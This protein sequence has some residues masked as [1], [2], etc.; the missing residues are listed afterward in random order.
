MSPAPETTFIQFSSDDL[1]TPNRHKAIV[2]LYDHGL[3]PTNLVPLAESDPHVDFIRWAMP[4]LGILS[5]AI[6]GVRH[7]GLPDT[8]NQK[9]DDD[10]FLHICLTGTNLVCQRGREVTLGDG[11]AVLMTR[12]GTG[13][14][15]TCPTQVN[16]IGLRLP[17]LAFV[18]LVPNLDDSTG[19]LIPRDAGA[20]KLLRKYLSVIADTETLATPQLRSLAVTQIYDLVALTIGATGDA[21][22]VAEN[23]GVRAA[24]LQA[25]KTDIIA[26]LDDGDLNVTAVAARN[27]LTVRYLH[28]LFE[29]EGIRYSEFVLDQ[30]LTRAH[31]ILTSPIHAHRAIGMI[32][33]EAGFNDLSYFNRAFR[34]RYNA[35]PSEVR[36]T[37]AQS[38]RSLVRRL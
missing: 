4:G 1:P 20:L 29:T 22:E 3:L 18:Q 11:D 16:F 38:Q 13:W 30:R 21:H 33:F 28:K 26:N 2:E 31:R 12:E 6:S 19:C 23:R 7:Q 17:R 8:A 34:R 36:N 35:T 14:A 37:L 24:R 32:A 15:I 25:I 5:G 10:L 9:R 27:R